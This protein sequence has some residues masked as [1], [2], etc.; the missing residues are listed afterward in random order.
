MLTV[1]HFWVKYPQCCGTITHLGVHL[2]RVNMVWG[3][4]PLLNSCNRCIYVTLI[5][6]CNSREI[7]GMI[8]KAL[9]LQMRLGISNFGQKK[10]NFCPRLCV[11]FPV[12][13]HETSL[14]CHQMPLFLRQG[15]LLFCTL[16]LFLPHRAS[17]SKHWSLQR[18]C[19]Y[20]LPFSQAVPWTWHRMAAIRGSPKPLVFVWVLKNFQYP[21]LLWVII[22]RNILPVDRVKTLTAIWHIPRNST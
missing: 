18:C 14:L 21:N 20:E 10:R 12:C 17:T 13:F 6:Y 5:N 7:Q 8:T 11:L 4:Q 1:C 9:L 22:G 2:P 3:P 19:G 15:A 16:M